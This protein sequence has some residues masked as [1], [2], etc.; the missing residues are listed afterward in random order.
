MV[1]QGRWINFDDMKLVVD[2]YALRNGFQVMHHL[3]DSKPLA[4]E[5][6]GDTLPVAVGT[7]T[8][9]ISTGDAAERKA[10]RHHIYTT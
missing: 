10:H 4:Q 1:L 5:P 8:S 2:N 3:K 6:S 7:S 9:P